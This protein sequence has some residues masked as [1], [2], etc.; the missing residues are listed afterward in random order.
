MSN[1]LQVLSMMAIPATALLTVRYLNTRAGRV[2]AVVPVSGS[3]A[4]N[5]PHDG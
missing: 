1:V 4:R 2:T 5:T 3:A